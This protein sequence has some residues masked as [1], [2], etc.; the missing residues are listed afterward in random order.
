M[1]YLYRIYFSDQCIRY[2][3]ALTKTKNANYMKNVNL[4]TIVFLSLIS[5]S[6]ISCK[7]EEPVDDNTDPGS[8]KMVAETT[9]T[10][11]DVATMTEEATLMYM[12]DPNYDSYTFGPCVIVLHDDV[13]TILTFD[14]GTTGCTG[15]DGRTRMGKIIVDYNGI[16]R[17]PGSTLSIT[18]DGYSVDGYSV[19]GTLNYNT[20]NYNGEGDLEISYSIENGEYTEP[21]GSIVTLECSRTVTW[22]AGTGSE[23]LYD[24]V[25]ETTGNFSG[26]VDGSIYSGEITEPV[27]FKS[28]CWLDGIYYPVSGE[29]TLDFP[30]AINRSIN[31]GDGDCDRDIVIRIGLINYPY[32]LP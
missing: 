10:Y 9:K 32:T 25:F 24:D 1:L 3:F 17:E 2:N 8:A 21:D 11:D 6:V 27:V 14:L 20:L 19:S 12:E 26:S 7:K 16:P 30:D 31:Y 5:L 23:N 4:K 13:N 22:T 28:M 18:L 29:W 15:L